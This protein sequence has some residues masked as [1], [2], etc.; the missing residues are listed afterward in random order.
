MSKIFLKSTR[1]PIIVEKKVAEL[2]QKDYI[3]KTKSEDQMITIPHSLGSLVTTFGDIRSVDVVVND[4]DFRISRNEN[5]EKI[6][7]EAQQ[8]KPETPEEKQE[9]SR[10][11]RMIRDAMGWN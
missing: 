10:R 2:I 4:N 9:F 6:Y 5:T 8:I 11:A 1:M 7:A 3:E